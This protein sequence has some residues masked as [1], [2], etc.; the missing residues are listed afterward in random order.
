MEP[1]LMRR[2]CAITAEEQ[3]L[4]RGNA[5]DR[6][7]YT[8]SERFLVDS[9]HLLRKGEMIALRPHTRFVDFPAHQ[10][11]YIEI[12]YMV[13]GQTRHTVNNGEKLTLRGGEL[14]LMNQHAVH[15]ISA[16]GE[17]DL[18][19]NVIVRPAFFDSVLGM[20]GTDNVLGRFLLDSLRE[21]SMGIPYLYFQVAEIEP[22]QLVL[23]CMVRGLAYEI[24]NS[25]KIHQVSMGLLFLH[26]LNHTEQMRFASGQQQMEGIAIAA[27]RE[28]EENYRSANLSAL[29][30]RLG[31]SLSYLSRAVK[32]AT[33]CSY[34]LL[35]QQK[36]MEKAAALLQQSSL[37]VS[38][39]M[40][41]V[42]YH[43][44][45]HFYHLFE[46]MFHVSP[47]TYRKMKAEIK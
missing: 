13:S 37:T 33:G 40:Q 42:G 4:L 14:L 31:C 36:R 17:G 38:E 5:L 24:P 20:I 28:I 29:A 11:N 35:L 1:E 7:L 45:S 43:N 2:L 32:K 16:A 41:A 3:E 8:S 25:R 9:G 22:V 15:A 10:H 44:S 30:A 47:R 39:V 27:L 34:A 19:V 46:D 6:A 12:T 18:A 26:L 23:E 21:Q